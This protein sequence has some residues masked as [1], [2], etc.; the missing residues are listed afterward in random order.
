MLD[1]AGRV[2]LAVEL[3]YEPAAFVALEAGDWPGNVRELENVVSRAI[4]RASSR[5]G[6]GE[7]VLVRES[8]LD[9]RER[10]GGPRAAARASDAAAG[11]VSSSTDLRESGRAAALAALD[12]GETMRAALERHERELIAAAIER[13]SGNWASAARA[14]DVDRSNLHRMARRLGLK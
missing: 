7:V 4:L 9:V 11:P 1:E 8:D 13:A 10:S 5:V 3:R 6:G 12:R 2:E 14:L